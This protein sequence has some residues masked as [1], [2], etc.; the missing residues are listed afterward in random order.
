MWARWIP[1]LW[2]FDFHLLRGR[3]QPASQWALMRPAAEA[4]VMWEILSSGIWGKALGTSP[5]QFDMAY[6]GYS[7]LRCISF[8]WHTIIAHQSKSLLLSLYEWGVVYQDVLWFPQCWHISL[9]FY[10]AHTNLKIT[11]LKNTRYEN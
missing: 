3:P 7:S 4:K 5:I 10:K 2:T 8:V 9:A 1:W 6:M 11:D